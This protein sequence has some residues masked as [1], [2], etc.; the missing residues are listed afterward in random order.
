MLV[1]QLRE[2]QAKTKYPN[3]DNYIFSR[4]DGRPIDPDHLQERVLYP[5]MDKAEIKRT[6]RAYGLHMFR[7][8]AGSI[9]Y[10]KTGKMKIV[11]RLLGRAQES[12]TSNIYVHTQEDEVAE[13]AEL[14]AEEIFSK[15]QELQDFSGGLVN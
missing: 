10:D 8:T 3:P 15:M 14:V 12:T 4:E 1:T 13:V 11:Q 9:G 6:S 5:A 2:H 7:H